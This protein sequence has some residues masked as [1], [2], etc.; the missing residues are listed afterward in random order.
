MKSIQPHN[1]AIRI[2]AL[3]FGLFFTSL[4]SIALLS[5]SGYLPAGESPDF[6]AKILTGIA[7]AVF[8]LAGLGMLLFGFGANRFAGMAAG[9]SLLLFLLAFNWI[10]F[11]PGERNFTRKVHSDFNGTSISKASET[12]GRAVF[13]IFAGL[14]DLALV[15]GLVRSKN[16]KT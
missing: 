7:S 15:Y 2:G 5:I 14:M 1:K 16:R 9:L 4:G 11:G 3:F 8:V 13:G 12:E 10:A 6:S